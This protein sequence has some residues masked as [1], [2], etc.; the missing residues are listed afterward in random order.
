MKKVYLEHS[1]CIHF[2]ANLDSYLLIGGSQRYFP[3]NNHTNEL[4]GDSA[5]GLP[6]HFPQDALTYFTVGGFIG[7]EPF[8]CDGIHFNNGACYSYSFEDGEWRVVANFTS[9]SSEYMNGA[10]LNA[11]QFW[12]FS[13]T[14]SLI[15][16]AG[17]G[18]SNG[19]SLPFQTYRACMVPLNKNQVVFVGRLGS[20]ISTSGSSGIFL[21]QVD[22]NTFHRLADYNGYGFLEHGCGRVIRDN[23]DVEIVVL[24]YQHVYIYSF[25]SNSWRFVQNGHPGSS[26]WHPPVVSYKNTFRVALLTNADNKLY[27]YD[28]ES[29]SFNAVLD[30]NTGS[31]PRMAGALIPIT[32][33]DV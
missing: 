4:L 2:S 3:L 26:T 13:N 28:P 21:Y 18:F 12:L 10:Q 31:S 25:S 29:G 17:Q 24:A 6:S 20:T 33:C 30:V 27:Q 32:N 22:T 7:G 8:V 16:T 11:D 1:P 15:Y 9:S 23:G 19:P 5:C 14:Q